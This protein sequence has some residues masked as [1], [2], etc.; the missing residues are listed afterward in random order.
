[1]WDE[2]DSWSMQP[3]LAELQNSESKK[4]G[5]HMDFLQGVE[6]RFAVQKVKPLR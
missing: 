1:M 4:Y 6:D 3:T 2:D 5:D